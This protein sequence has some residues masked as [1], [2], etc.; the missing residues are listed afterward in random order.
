MKNEYLPAAKLGV[1][2]VNIDTDGRLVWT[3]VHREFFRDQPEQFD[4]RPPGKIFVRGIRELHRAQ[5]REARL[6]RATR[7]DPRQLVMRIV[8][9]RLRLRREA[10]CRPA[11]FVARRDFFWVFDLEGQLHKFGLDADRAKDRKAFCAG[12]ESRRQRHS[13]LDCLRPVAHS[14]W[15]SRAPCGRHVFILQ[16]ETPPLVFSCEVNDER[17]FA[18]GQRVADFRIVH[19]QA[20]RFRLAW[21][22]TFDLQPASFRFLALWLMCRLLGRGIVGARGRDQ[23]QYQHRP[24]AQPAYRRKQRRDRMRTWHHFNHSFN[25]ANFHMAFLAR[26]RGSSVQYQ[27]V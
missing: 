16:S 26:P 8:P 20:G 3:R 15:R 27:L 22:N 9:A 18:V 1:T 7:R 23:A 12:R 21:G 25:R 14:R 24:D 17:G 2:K 19:P 4:F 10:A 11:G 5:E 13:N 6:G